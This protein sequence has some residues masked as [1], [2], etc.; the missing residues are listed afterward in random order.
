[1]T[2]TYEQET[3]LELIDYFLILLSPLAVVGM[4]TLI[5]NVRKNRIARLLEDGG[6]MKVTEISYS[7]YKGE[8][9]TEYDVF[10]TR[11][12]STT[13]E[14]WFCGERLFKS[15]GSVSGDFSFESTLPRDGKV[16]VQRKSGDYEFT[17]KKWNCVR[18]KRKKY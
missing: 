17:F 13:K 3:L 7:P 9:V 12:S 1:M 18:Q 2:L 10:S 16:S 5:R 11:K 8:I 6:K 4:T 14:W 15:A